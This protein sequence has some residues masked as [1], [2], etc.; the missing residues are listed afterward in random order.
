MKRTPKAAA[1]L[2]LAVMAITALSGCSAQAETQNAVDKKAESR[3]GFQPV[4]DVEYNN[5]IA[6]QK[7]YDDPNTI[8]WCTTSFASSASPLI[9]VPIRGKLTSSST[10]FFAAFNG[11]TENRSVDGMYHG[12]PPPYRYGFTPG[13]A[14]VSLEAL[15]AFCTTTLNDFQRQ[16]TFISVEGAK[17]TV[18]DAQAKAED[19]L[20]AG[21]TAEA[22]KVL[23]DAVANEGVK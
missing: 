22:N 21:K 7:L 9:T 14:Y 10:S 15:G 2:A 13:G 23:K 19:L 16:K 17:S 5:Y 1:V 4:N 12:S 18:D 6:A 20:K 11:T 3:S 8:I